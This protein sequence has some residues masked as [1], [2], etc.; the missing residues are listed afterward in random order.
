MDF[1][2]SQ[3]AHYAVGGQGNDLVMRV[4]PAEMVPIVPPKAGQGRANGRPRPSEPPNTCQQPPKAVQEPPKRA[5]E[6]PKSAPEP[7]E[8][9]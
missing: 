6:A 4:V 2:R 8:C 1:L 3:S 5:Q 7:P 9:S